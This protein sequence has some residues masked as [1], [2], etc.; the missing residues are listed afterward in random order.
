MIIKVNQLE[1]GMVLQKDLFTLNGD[2]ILAAGTILNEDF[3]SRIERR[4]VQSVDVLGDQST[5]QSKALVT[6]KNTLDLAFKNAVDHFKQIY[7]TVKEGG[8]LGEA[9]I[10]E[11]SNPIVEEILHNSSLMRQLWAMTQY[12]DYTFEHSVSVSIIS[13]LL[14][15]WLGNSDSLVKR[16]TVA[17]LFHDIGKVDI[18]EMLFNSNSTLTPEQEALV[19]THPVKGYSLLKEQSEISDQVLQAVLHHH[20]QFDGGG[21][22]HGLAGEEISPLARIVSIAD[23][24]VNMTKPRKADES[25]NPY[26]ASEKIRELSYH[27][28]DAHYTRLFI[29][30][31][32]NFFV[33]NVVKLSEGSVGEVVLI[34]RTRPSR[35]LVKTESDFIDL[36]T[37]NDIDIVSIIY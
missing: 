24:Y 36:N 29:D 27:K 34:N 26:I 33:G 1:N 13:G 30:G 32:S 17:G 23:V 15:K 14:A 8:E 19:K 21:Y 6:S 28:L 2:L 3:I 16:A 5:L 25:I 12:D 18:P 9:V 10:D 35:P 31:I 37:R 22:P 20:E 7:A 11:I 4:G